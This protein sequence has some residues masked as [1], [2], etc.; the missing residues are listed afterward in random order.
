MTVTPPTRKDMAEFFRFGLLAGLCEPSTVARWAESIVA[1]DELPHI[2]FIELCIAG[3]QP[4]SH[5]QALLHDVPGDPTPELATRM[6]LGHASGLISSHA[7]APEQILLR[8][9]G[10]A[11]R[12][13]FPERVWSE[14]VSLE[15][16]LSLA[17]DGV[18]GTLPEV[19]TGIIEFLGNY[20]AYA[21]DDVCGLAP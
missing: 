21:P 9:Y 6:L 2:A 13:T 20:A 16:G 5:V 4:A 18:Y 8:L 11:T 7:F 19:A 3:S 12:E 17:R 14:L 15:D 1:A 10:I